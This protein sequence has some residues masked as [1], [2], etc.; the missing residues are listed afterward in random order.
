MSQKNKTVQSLYWYLTS[1][2]TIPFFQGLA[3]DGC[4][5]WLLRWARPCSSWP[6]RT[7]GCSQSSASPCA[8]RASGE[9]PLAHTR[10]SLRFVLSFHHQGR[11]W[12]VPVPS[13]SLSL[14]FFSCGTWSQFLK[15][16]PKL[17]IGFRES[18][19]YFP[20]WFLER[21]FVTIIN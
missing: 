15:S 18:S 6:C 16:V 1:A 7:G 8:K 3:R 14:F 20:F 19:E 12:V 17:P 21:F 9:R 11:G 13:L 5:G 10:G 2:P 4:S